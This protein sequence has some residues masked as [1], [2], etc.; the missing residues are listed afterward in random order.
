VG[1]PKYS[2]LSKQ[3]LTR[4]C[5]GEKAQKDAD[6]APVFRTSIDNGRQPPLAM[7]DS[8]SPPPSVAQILNKRSKAMTATTTS[9]QYPRGSMVT[10]EKILAAR[11]DEVEQQIEILRRGDRIEAKDM[12]RR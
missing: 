11:T 7:F 2:Q 3:G 1:K 4:L 6:P 5:K 8:N 10:D 12:V 9:N